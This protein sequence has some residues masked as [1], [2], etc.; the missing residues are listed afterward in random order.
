M[1][2]EGRISPV[3]V[4]GGGLLLVGGAA[5]LAYATSRKKGEIPL[6]AGW[7]EVTY[8]GRKQ[9]AGIAFPTISG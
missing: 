1:A 3:V 2:E 9:K 7:N 4:I 8:S 6:S 5:A